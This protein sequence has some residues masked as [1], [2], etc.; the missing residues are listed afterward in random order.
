MTA[1][2]SGRVCGESRHAETDQPYGQV[3][4]QIRKRAVS[5][6]RRRLQREITAR[7]DTDDTRRQSLAIL[8]V[9]CRGCATVGDQ[10]P[11]TVDPLVLCNW[12]HG[13][14]QAPG[15]LDT[16][17]NTTTRTLLSGYPAMRAARSHASCYKGQAD[18]PAQGRPIMA[19]RPLARRVGLECRIL[20][21]A[22]LQ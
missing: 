12:S 8:S 3:T 2:V 20:R 21:S 19:T 10:A 14:K 15:L 13:E 6:C 16:D 11:G 9:T 7:E 22:D 18:R 17:G 5:L 1:I 4:S